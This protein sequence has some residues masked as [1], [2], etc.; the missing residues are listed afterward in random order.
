M[1]T[2]IQQQNQPARAER[3]ANREFVLPPANIAA[4]DNGY[5][6]E[7]E[8]PGVDKSGLEISVEG[9][10]LSIIGR[11]KN[12]VPEGQLYYSEWPQADFRRTFDLGPDVDTARI[13]AQLEQGVLK[14]RLPK[15]ERSKPRKIEI[16]G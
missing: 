10:E 14:L 12:D 9:N 5:L 2:A 6:V 1:N 16:S 11:R 3:Q 13:A 15:S 4:T 7:V 8:M